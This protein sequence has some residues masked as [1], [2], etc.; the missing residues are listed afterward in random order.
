MP[1][2][3]RPNHRTNP[4]PDPPTENTR[5]KPHTKKE[6]PFACSASSLCPKNTSKEPQP[7]TNTMDSRGINISG[8][9][10]WHAVEFSKNGRF[11]Q[12]LTG[13]PGTFPSTSPTLPDPFPEPFPI[14]NIRTP[15]TPAGRDAFRRSHHISRHPRPHKIRQSPRQIP[16]HRKQPHER[17]IK[18][19]SQPRQTAQAAAREP[20]QPRG[21]SAKTTPGA[22]EHPNLRQTSFS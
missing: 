21:N 12:T 4:N 16:A 8:V 22:V 2:R 18:P 9:D 14:P 7:S 17:E 6:K 20:Q 15:I 11:H 5:A 1:K 19:S 10:F 13:P 3:K